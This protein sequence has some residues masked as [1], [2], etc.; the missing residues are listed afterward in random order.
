MKLKATLCIGISILLASIIITFVSLKAQTVLNDSPKITLQQLA[1]E[2][3]IIP[4]EIQKPQA[5]FKT[6]NSVEGISFVIKNNTQKQIRS[7]CFAYSIRIERNKVETK[8]TF[9]HT[10]DTFVHQDIRIG[11]NLKPITPGQEEV[12]SEN[13]ETVFESGSKITGIDARIDYVEFED[14]TTL[15]ANEKGAKIISLIRE[16]AAKYKDWLIQ[17]YKNRKTIDA[18]VLLIQSDDLPAELKFDSNYQTIGVKNYRR[19]VRN[20]YTTQGVLDLENVISK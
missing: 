2:N 17:Q 20:L 7:I 13:G 14:G 16:G 18:I 8:D 9:F 1:I 12:L 3:G 6:P 5:N 15:G 4:V 19:Y 11:R 10:L